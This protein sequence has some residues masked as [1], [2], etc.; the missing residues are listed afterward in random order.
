MLFACFLKNGTTER[1]MKVFFA[2]SRLAI[3]V[4]VQRKFPYSCPLWAIRCVADQGRS[5]RLSAVGP[6]ATV[7]L[8]CSECPLSAIR[9]IRCDVKNRLTFLQLY[10]ATLWYSMPERASSTASIAD[11][12]LQHSGGCERLGKPLLRSAV[13]AMIVQFGVAGV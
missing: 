1:T 13:L 11:I 12:V 7:T 9:V 3:W 8:Q 5:G 6:I 2:P 4:S 10:R